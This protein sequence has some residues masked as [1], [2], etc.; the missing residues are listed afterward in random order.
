MFLQYYCCN[1]ILWF[2]L[3]NR[4]AKCYYFCLFYY[5]QREEYETAEQILHVAL[6]LA[7]E[8]QNADGVTYVYDLLANVAFELGQ[9]EKAQKLFVIVMQREIANGIPNNDMKI[10]HMSLKLAKIYES[11]KDDE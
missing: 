7:Q 1:F 11:L 3:T 5:L 9:W 10:I 2:C 4:Q 6:R 8:Q